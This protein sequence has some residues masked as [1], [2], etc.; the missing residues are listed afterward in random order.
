VT[1]DLIGTTLIKNGVTS[2][3]IKT[4]P[5]VPVGSFELNLPQ[6]PYSALAAN[7]SLCGKTSVAHKRVKG[8]RRS[9]KKTTPLALTMPTEFIAQN[10]APFRQRTKIAVSGCAKA[11]A[12]A[13]GKRAKGHRRK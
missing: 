12:R 10:G 9:I 7:T 8:R 1:V 5:D 11:H 2:T 13:H 3:T 6:G 4:V